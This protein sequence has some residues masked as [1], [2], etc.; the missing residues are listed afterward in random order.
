MVRA[1][2][3]HNTAAEAAHTEAR[4]AHIAHAAVVSLHALCCGAPVVMLLLASAATSAASGFI[5]RTHGFL[6]QHELW[7]IAVSFSLLV[8]GGVSE[9]RAR[10]AG[11]RRFP[12]LFALSFACLIANAAI[13]IVHRL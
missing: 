11:L 5:T 2:L 6:H 9:W 3:Q 1:M 10:Q 4:R 12:V 13:L 7:L 8:L